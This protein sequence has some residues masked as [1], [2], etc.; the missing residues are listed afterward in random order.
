MGGTLPTIYQHAT[1]TDIFAGLLST[2]EPGAE[3]ALPGA[4]TG[5]VGGRKMA[6]DGGTI[7]AGAPLEWI[8]DVPGV[9]EVIGFDNHGTG[10]GQRV[11]AGQIVARFMLRGADHPSVVRTAEQIL[12]RLEENLGIALIIGEKD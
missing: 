8:A 7:S 11:S 6:R 1:G 10:P 12:R 3:V 5:C 2:L 9:L 4:L